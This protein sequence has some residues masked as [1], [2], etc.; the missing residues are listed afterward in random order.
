MPTCSRVHHLLLLYR[1]TANASAS[2]HLSLTNA[3]VSMSGCLYSIHTHKSLTFTFSTLIC[4]SL[5]L[6][7]PHRDW[8]SCQIHPGTS[9]QHLG[10]GACL[11]HLQGCPLPGPLCVLMDHLRT[12]MDS[13]SYLLR[14][15]YVGSSYLHL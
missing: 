8:H 10:D 11:L 1:A 4:A 15:F 2:L 6:M 12:G 7:H 9:I 3:E 13:A 14:T 5:F